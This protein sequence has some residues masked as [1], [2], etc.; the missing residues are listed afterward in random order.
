MK[1][2]FYKSLYKKYSFLSLFFLGLIVGFFR[3]VPIEDLSQPLIGE[4]ALNNQ[5]N[6]SDTIFLNTVLSDNFGIDTVII[7]I[8]PAETLSRPWTNTKKINNVGAR[9]LELK[10]SSIIVPSSFSLGKYE[11]TITTIDISGLQNTISREFIV[12]ADATK[13]TFPDV[14]LPN[15]QAFDDGSYPACRLEKVPLGGFITDNVGIKLITAQFETGTRIIN[16]TFSTNDVDSVNLATVFGNELVF[17]DVPND[18]LLTLIITAEDFENNVRSVSI[19]FTM[20][21]DTQSPIIEKIKVNRPF[22]EIGEIEVIQGQKLFI[23]G[24]IVRDSL[25]T[26]KDVYVYFN[27]D[28][29]PLISGENINNPIFNLVGNDSV[30]V[31]I[32][33]NAQNQDTYTIK[34]E[35]TDVAGNAPT[36]RE[37]IIDILPNEA[38]DIELGLN[39]I[40]DEPSIFNSNPNNPPTTLSAGATIR[41]E[42]KII[43]DVALDS[44]NVSW[45][46]NNIEI[47][48]VNLDAGD[49]VNR[50]VISIS[51]N[52][53]LVDQNDRIGTRYTLTISATDTFNQTTQITYYFIVE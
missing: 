14:L 8:K 22:N 20:N 15:I 2:L 18:S 49:L 28:P 35:A 40:N 38:P 27:N 4:F 50:L 3:C 32:P 43:E 26:L 10:D 37:F 33:S 36:T 42:T 23:T 29:T 39:Y 53:F 12:G 51:N 34:V 41:T 11:L 48:G 9:V 1:F 52:R 19:N 17:L 45:K 25:G 6:V 5:Y 24:G 47:D 30:F 21:C 16:R 44:Y 13:P 31:P 7:D 46:R